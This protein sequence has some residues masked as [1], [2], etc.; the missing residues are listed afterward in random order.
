MRNWTEL[1]KNVNSEVI[2]TYKNGLS[3]LK[4]FHSTTHDNIASTVTNESIG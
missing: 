2:Y 3:S 4:S 1:A